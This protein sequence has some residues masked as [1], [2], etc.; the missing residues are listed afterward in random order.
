MTVLSWGTPFDDNL[1]SSGVLSVNDTASG[2]SLLPMQNSRVDRN[3][4]PRREDMIDLGPLRA[5]TKDVPLVS[6]EWKL[7]RGRLY[8]IRVKGVWK[9]VWHASVEDIGERALKLG[10]G[11]TGV[12]GWDFEEVLRVEGG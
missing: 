3:M 8:D 11:P 5:V 12:V 7:E 6:E 2:M 4:A 9:V 1:F 10:A